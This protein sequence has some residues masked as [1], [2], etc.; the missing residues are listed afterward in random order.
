MKRLQESNKFRPIKEF[1]NFLAI[2]IRQKSTLS[3]AKSNNHDC[4]EFSR[5]KLSISF[6]A[7]ELRGCRL[8]FFKKQF[9]SS[10]SPAVLDSWLRCGPLSVLLTQQIQS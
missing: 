7:L 10:G 3:L 8:L 6:F 2:I 1:Q 5:K 9:F 4:R